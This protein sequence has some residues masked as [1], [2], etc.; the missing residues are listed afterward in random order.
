MI[1]SAELLSL[2]YV[3]LARPFCPINA[4]GVDTI[5]LDTI[6]QGQPFVVSTGVDGLTKSIPFHQ[7]RRPP[8]GR[9]RLGDWGAW[10][11]LK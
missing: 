2:E 11:E 6:F 7:A 8:Q 4:S 5:G 3:Y 9:Y 1:T 10:Q